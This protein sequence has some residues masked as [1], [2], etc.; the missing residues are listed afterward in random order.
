MRA[1]RCSPVVIKYGGL[2]RFCQTLQGCSK[3]VFSLS[4]PAALASAASRF[5]C[6][7]SIELKELWIDAATLQIA[8]HGGHW[9][10]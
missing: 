2:M 5:G 1:L 3:E 10:D 6:C 7:R 8:P 9:R 4:H